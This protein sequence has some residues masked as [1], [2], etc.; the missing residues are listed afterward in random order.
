MNNMHA[1]RVF[2]ARL[3][4]FT[5]ALVAAGFALGYSDAVSPTAAAALAPVAAEAPVA[6]SVE[7]AEDLS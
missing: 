5:V 2:S 3:R 7:T 6:D 1:I 4:L